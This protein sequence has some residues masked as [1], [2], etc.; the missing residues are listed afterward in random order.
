MDSK[1]C[2]HVSVGSLAPWYGCA[3]QRTAR[4]GKPRLNVLRV[5][6][7]GCIVADTSEVRRACGAGNEAVLVR[8]EVLCSEEQSLDGALLTMVSID[9][10]R[11]LLDSQGHRTAHLTGPYDPDASKCPREPVKQL[12]L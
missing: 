4:N 1:V 9:Q 8:P 11:Y 10:L 5:I 3:C 12:V 7:E 2:R 6:P